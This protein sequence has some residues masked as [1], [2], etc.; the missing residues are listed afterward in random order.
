MANVDMDEFAAIY[1]FL[2]QALATQSR[3]IVELFKLTDG[4]L[5]KETARTIHELLRPLS[6]AAIGVPERV[7]ALAMLDR[8]VAM[9]PPP[10]D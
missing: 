2:A 7:S 9:F 8:M 10:T 4:K 1:R 5:P 6:E 3:I